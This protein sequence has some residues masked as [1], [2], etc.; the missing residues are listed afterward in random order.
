MLTLD[1]I[2]ELLKKLSPEEMHCVSA[3]TA[4][5]L[6]ELLKKSLPEQTIKFVKPGKLLKDTRPL[7]SN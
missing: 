1:Q 7:L 4:E 5:T 3:M 2:T 6:T